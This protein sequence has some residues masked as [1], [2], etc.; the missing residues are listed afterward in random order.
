MDNKFFKNPFIVYH[1]NPYKPEYDKKTIFIWNCP[2]LVKNKITN[3][4][5]DDNIIKNYFGP[6]YK[7]KLGLEKHETNNIFHENLQMISNLTSSKNTPNSSTTKVGG[8]ISDNNLII[9]STRDDDIENF[10]NSSGPD[11]ISSSDDM[12]FNI[13]FDNMKTDSI[14]SSSEDILSSEQLEGNEYIFDTSVYPEDNI[15]ALKNK[16][17]LVCKIPIY[18]QLLF[19]NGINIETFHEIY[20]NDILYNISPMDDITRIYNMGID[21]KLFLGRENMR[22]KAYDEFNLVGNLKHNYIFLVDLK[23]YSDVLGINKIKILDDKLYLEA[24]YYGFIKKYFPMLDFEGFKLYLTNEHNLLLKYPLLVENIHTLEGKY[25]Y[26]KTFLDNTY[27]MKI[28][29]IKEI[30][31]HVEIAAKA[32][33][34]GNI[35]N[36]N[37]NLLNVRNIFDTIVTDTSIIKIITKFEFNNEVYEITKEHMNVRY[38]TNIDINFELYKTYLKFKNNGLVLYYCYEKNDLETK[39]ATFVLFPTGKYYII[40]KNKE[41]DKTSFNKTIAL[42]IDI[43]NKILKIIN[44]NISIILNKNI[45]NFSINYLTQNSIKFYNLDIIMY[46]NMSLSENKFNRY[47]MLF[48]DLNKFGI[49]TLANIQTDN[50]IF[51]KFNKSVYD[52]GDR[53]F[54]IKKDKESKNYYDAYLDAG[55]NATWKLLF[56]GKKLNITNS[57]TRVTYEM[58][59]LVPEELNFIY[60]Y[61]LNTIQTLNSTPSQASN[62]SKKNYI[63]KSDIKK[64]EE[65]DPELYAQNLGKDKIYSRI[66]QKKNRPTIYSLDEYD[67]MSAKDKSKMVKYWNFTTNKPIYYACEDPK[68]K[69]FSFVTGKHP[70]GYCF[71][72]CRDVKNKGKKMTF[73]YNQCMTKHCTG[74]YEEEKKVEN[75]LKYK[76]E[77]VM[78]KKYYFPEPVYDFLYKLDRDQLYFSTIN[79]NYN[80]VN[81][82]SLF[83]IY[84]EIVDLDPNTFVRDIIKKLKSYN[85]LD[86]ETL[87][88][89][90]SSIE[91]L[92]ASLELHFIKNMQS[93]ESYWNSVFEEILL[94]LYNVCIIGLRYDSKLYMNIRQD[95]NNFKYNKFIITFNGYKVTYKKIA[96]FDFSDQIIEDIIHYKNNVKLRTDNIINSFSYDNIIKKIDAS[97]I[98]NIY[99]TGKKITNIVYNKNVY[100]AVYNSPMF[101]S[102][103]NIYNEI[104]YRD[105]HKISWLDTYKFI[106]SIVNIEPV[107]V[108]Y[109]KNLENIVDINNIP[110]KTTVIGMQVSTLYFWFNDTK[111][112]EIRNNVSNFSVEVINFEPS[113][114]NELLKNNRNV[115]NYID[116]HLTDINFKIYYNNMFKMYKIATYNHIL[117]TYNNP[118]KDNILNIIKNKNFSTNINA[119]ISEIMKILNY[120]QDRDIIIPLLNDYKNDKLDKK[121]LIETIE[122]NQFLFDLDNIKRFSQ[123][124]IKDIKDYL[125]SEGKKYIKLIDKSELKLDK[126]ISNIIT[127]CSSGSKSEWCNNKK[128]LILE[129]QYEDFVDVMAQNLNNG[130]YSYHDIININFNIIVDYFKFNKHPGEIIY[131]LS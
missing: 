100:I 112:E 17:F 11:I 66:V 89:Y 63:A 61:I 82:V 94:Y 22:V 93:Y 1:I 60:Y 3:K 113:D 40:I 119:N 36:S 74:V 120:K 115:K 71:P 35:H 64:L 104:Y 28:K 92:C 55:A 59:N 5:F 88:M 30:E 15:L 20:V 43:V 53:K 110:P 32:I 75:L 121:E 85:I 62:N 91:D 126:S 68:F 122:R 51:S 123:I 16:I 67:K 27:T 103:K 2:P 73:L 102:D 90:F 19:Y 70:K 44:D 116:E 131:L 128:L 111:Y 95:I 125:M 106:Q 4:Q 39:V 8:D 97:K 107:F 87:N 86:F 33:K 56:G 105:S 114:I 80:N 13:D 130:P 18:R 101:N 108:V 47:K 83:K 99:V 41:E 81:S 34:M 25:M 50:Q 29:N 79:P 21:K 31:K 12:D 10:S 45:S 117:K 57:I 46:L 54:I 98:T 52:Y 58:F 78:G 38:D 124:D 109:D 129:D 72:V 23:T 76:D 37:S 24:M 96:L 26:E 118:I 65:L 127:T 49:I 6:D 9:K 42:G 69:H 7:T 14:A 84:I 48:N 77:L